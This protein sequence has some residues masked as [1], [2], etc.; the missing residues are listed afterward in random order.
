MADVTVSIDEDVL[1]VLKELAAH[2]GQTLEDYL[3]GMLLEDIA[4]IK[5]RM[6]DPIIGSFRSGAGDISERDE[7]IIY[8]E[9][10]PD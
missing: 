5:Q 2:R 4:R 10:E 8:Q 3:R 7:E 9:W 6:N 1:E